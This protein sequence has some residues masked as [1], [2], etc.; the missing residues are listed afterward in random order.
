MNKL[1][2]TIEKLGFKADIG[3]DQYDSNIIFF[4]DKTGY[5]YTCRSNTPEWEL[6]FG[7]ILKSRRKDLLTI[8]EFYSVK[9]EHKL[10]KGILEE[11]ISYCYSAPEE[12]RVLCSKTDDIQLKTIASILGYQ[13][14]Q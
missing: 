2:E 8:A 3:Y 4:L 14:R 6:V 5:V 1:K 11:F 10:T 7:Q 9:M 13:L 12:E